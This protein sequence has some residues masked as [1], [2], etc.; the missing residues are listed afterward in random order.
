MSFKEVTTL[1]ADVTIR[2]GGVDKKTGKPNPQSAEGY[3]LGTRKVTSPK[4]KSGFASLHFLLTPN[5]NRA[6]WGKTDMDRKFSSVQ[7]GTMV[8]ISFDK[9]VPT[10]NGDMYKYKLEQDATNNIEVDFM[11]SR[12]TTAEEGTSGVGNECAELDG[13]TNDPEENNDYEEQE[14][15][16]TS[17]LA[18]LERK[19]KVEALL[20]GNRTN[21]K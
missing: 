12:S 17:A 4:S 21:R 10:P 13:L 1:D 20:K 14:A 2:L 5:G 15:V 16:Q 6:I 18:A 19:Q 9:M 3:Y 8:R 11:H 7:P